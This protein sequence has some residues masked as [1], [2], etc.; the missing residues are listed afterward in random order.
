M[1]KLNQIIQ[2]LNSEDFDNIFKILIEGSAEKSAY[3]FK[4]LKEGELRDSEIMEDLKVNAN[5]YYTLR[6]RL[7]QRIEEYLLQKMESPRA[8]LLKK[9]ANIHEVIFTQKRA[10]AIATL[11]KLEKELLDYDLSN[12]LTI[13]Y[14]YLKKLHL[15][16][17]DHFNYRQLYNQQVAF[18][19]AIDQQEDDLGEYFKK[20]GE[21]F[22]SNNESL[23]VEMDLLSNK[24]DNTRSLYKSHRLFVY[25]NCQEIFSALF[26]EEQKDFRTIKESFQRL[27]D[28]FE[29]YYLDST[30]Y[31]LES[32]LEA[33]QFEVHLQEGNLKEA[34][35]YAEGLRNQILKLVQNYQ[36]F[37]F[38]TIFLFSFL[39]WKVLMGEERELIEW[40]KQ[41]FKHYEPDPIHIPG[42]VTYYSYRAI[43]SVIAGDIDEGSRFLNTLLN[44]ISFKGYAETQ[45]EVKILLAVFYGLIDDF[46]LF[47]QLAHSIQRQIRILG[48]EKC[49]HAV[50]LI[51]LLKTHFAS[52][53][54]NKNKKLEDFLGLIS[55]NFPPHFSPTRE[56][57][58]TGYLEK[59]LLP[60]S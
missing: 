48:K 31:H 53:K 28:I 20:Y 7:N 49:M 55:Q 24:L 36:S 44:E 2:D 51:K 50:Y 18:N 15:N 13:V 41:A 1:A 8:D 39:Q 52:G 3:L 34:G 58:K 17:E 35:T 37:T 16:S 30:Y 6:S 19:L 11:K 4:F 29:T 9:V 46:E 47:S 38:P 54:K 23:K 27:E 33:L 56:L 5:A 14:K 43:C 26:L 32:L 40:N 59:V 21:Y 10:I 12:E 57:F 45:M 60:V 22:L 42:F 25:K